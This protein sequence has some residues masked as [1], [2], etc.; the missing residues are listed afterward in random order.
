VVDRKMIFD[1][2]LENK[3]VQAQ[4]E[5]LNYVFNNPLYKF[6]C[7]KYSDIPIFAFFVV[8]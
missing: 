7:K 2:Y 5:R 1:E 8:Y 3:E 4:L 6:I